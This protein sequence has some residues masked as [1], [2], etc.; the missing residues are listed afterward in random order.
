MSRFSKFEEN[1][2]SIQKLPYTVFFTSGEPTAYQ[3]ENRFSGKS[4][5]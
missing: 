5:Y 1:E 4:N 3:N 2:K